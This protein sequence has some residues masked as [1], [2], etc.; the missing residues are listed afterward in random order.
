ML[1]NM[2]RDVSQ[3][4]LKTS[5]IRRANSWR[6]CRSA[7]IH[8]ELA[9]GN[10]SR[11]PLRWIS[12]G[13]PNAGSCPHLAQRKPPAAWAQVFAI[14]GR[15]ETDAA[16]AADAGDDA[17]PGGATEASEPEVPWALLTVPPR[18]SSSSSFSFSS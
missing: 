16:G 13:T 2:L 14:D 11:V 3:A 18:P 15:D 6:R 10:P 1:R 8:T 12:D 17:G 5:G 7:D 9:F 4:L